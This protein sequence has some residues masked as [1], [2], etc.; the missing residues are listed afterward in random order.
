MKMKPPS[1]YVSSL[2]SLHD[3]L[4]IFVYKDCTFLIRLIPGYL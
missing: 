2:I 3:I 1:I 4:Y